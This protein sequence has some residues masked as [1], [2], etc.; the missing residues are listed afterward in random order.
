MFPTSHCVP[1]LRFTTVYASVAMSTSPAGHTI[2]REAVPHVA[3]DREASLLPAESGARA[4]QGGMNGS[5]PPPRNS[6]RTTSPITLATNASPSR[7]STEPSTPRSR[8][9]LREPV[10]R[11]ELAVHERAR[12]RCSASRSHRCDSRRRRTARSVR[13]ARTRMIASPP[14]LVSERRA[15]LPRSYVP[16]AAWFALEYGLLDRRRAERTRDPDP[17]E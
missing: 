3:G 8:I 11:H 16:A 13:A 2:L 12:R 4:G 10:E 9:R 6:P 17:A 7:V 5:A 1:A 14:V 15:A